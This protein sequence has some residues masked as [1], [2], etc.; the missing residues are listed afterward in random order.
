MDALQQDI[1]KII[2]QQPPFV[3]IDQLIDCSTGGASTK[4]LV[5]DDNVLVSKGEFTEAGLVENIA[6]T[7]AAG[8]GYAA[9]QTGGAI[10]TG[11]IGA[12]KNLEIFALPKTGDLLET[13]VKIENEIFDITII[14][15][16]VHGKGVLLASC[17]MKIFTKLIK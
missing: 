3:M 15:G 5:R 16:R 1:L 7:A 14:S 4:F 17:E 10:A 12:I 11:Y 6:Q 13:D 9:R 2:P 8:A